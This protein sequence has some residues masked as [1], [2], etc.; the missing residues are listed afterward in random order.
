MNEMEQ[1]IPKEFYE[2]EKYVKE[3][4][5]ELRRK[6]SDNYIAVLGNVGVIDYDKNRLDLARRIDERTHTKLNIMISSIEEILNP[7]EVDNL[8]SIEREE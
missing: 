8:P 5:Q 3:N 4:E 6:Y 1:E 2:A 7:T